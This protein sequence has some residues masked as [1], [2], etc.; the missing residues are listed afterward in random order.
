MMNDNL[1]N[2]KNK[3]CFV[4]GSNG[5]IGKAICQKLIKLGASQKGEKRNEEKRKQDKGKKIKGKKK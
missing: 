4:T 2:L 3:F 1:I 5:Y